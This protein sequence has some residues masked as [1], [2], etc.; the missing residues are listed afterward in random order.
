MELDDIIFSCK[1]NDY[2]VMPVSQLPIIDN[3]DEDIDG[4]LDQF[5][6]LMGCLVILCIRARDSVTCLGFA[7][8]F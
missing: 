4:A 7:R 3:C 1:L 8:L 5:W 6:F 2:H